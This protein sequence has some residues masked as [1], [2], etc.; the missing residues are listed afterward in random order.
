MVIIIG[1]GGAGLYFAWKYK[2]KNPKEETILVEEHTE[3]GKPVQCTGILTDDI[4]KLLP[5]EDIEKFTL[6]EITQTEV[7]SPNEKVCL[8]IKKDIIISNVGLI[9]YLHRKATK[10][11]VIMLDGHKYMGNEGKTV[12]I[13]DISTQKIKE[14]KTDKLVGADGP[15]SNVAKNNGI[16]KDRKFL[17]GVQARVKLQ[18]FDK[19]KI[20]FYPYIG[21]Y[22]WFTPE[23][24]D[25]ARIGLAAE[26][27]A[28][29]L[30]DEFIKKYPGQI[31]E[32]QGGPIP[33]HKPG[34]KVMKKTKGFT[35]ALLGDAALQIKNTT[36]GGIIP[37]M[38]A[39]K[40]LA[41]D[42]NNY[43]KNLKGLNRELYIHYIIN[44]MLKKYSAKDWDRLIRKTN[45]NG[46]KKTLQE[47]NRDNAL[48]MNA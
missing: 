33:L 28:R 5:P 39:A 11:G 31:L 13:K 44:K 26:R 36:G 17:T 1:G 30:F 14:Y 20:D 16:Y 29:L 8:K 22:A 27:N 7:Y 4:K 34:I 3:I 6:N 23:S 35:V 48:K 18:G 25:V 37:G 15:S 2:E 45:T 41:Q 42:F 19:T 10:A 24:D 40:I 46:V 38:K 12:R 9:K 21:E 32:M 47:I 43:K